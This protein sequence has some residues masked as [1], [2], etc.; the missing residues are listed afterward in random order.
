V[1]HQSTSGAVTGGPRLILRVEGLLLLALATWGFSVSG[2]AWWLYAALFFVPDL[3][4]LAYLAGPRAGAFVYNLLHSTIG[5]SLLAL[6]GVLVG[7][8]LA[9]IFLVGF[10]AIW[11]AHIGFD[12][13]LG[14]GL[15]YA[16]AFQDTHLGQIG[17]RRSTVSP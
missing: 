5:P 17:R 2:L 4:F 15:K 12:R 14:Y 9:G 11:A 6:A 8:S 7:P 3:S 13:M 16:T 10:A 1:V